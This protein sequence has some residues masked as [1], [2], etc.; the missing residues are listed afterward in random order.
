[1]D[2]KDLLGKVLKLGLIVATLFECITPNIVR[3][4]FILGY[5]LLSSMYWKSINYSLDDSILAFS[6]DY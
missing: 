2:T 1:M 3:A 5:G 4:Y 6:Y